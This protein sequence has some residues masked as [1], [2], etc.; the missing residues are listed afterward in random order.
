M[1]IDSLHGILLAS[2]RDLDNLHRDQRSNLDGE[3]FKLERD[4]A[5]LEIDLEGAN[6]AKKQLL[7]VSGNTNP[8]NAP[9]VRYELFRSADHQSKTVPADRFTALRPGDV[10]VVIAAGNENADVGIDASIPQTVQQASES[11]L[12]ILPSP[13]LLNI[14]SN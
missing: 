5:Q 8:D 3:I 2:Q 1:K 14:G 10:V 11:G 9:K 12:P 6:T 13:N 7:Q 4:T